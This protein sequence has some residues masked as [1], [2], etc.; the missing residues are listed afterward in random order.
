MGATA[1][2]TPIAKY[3]KKRKNCPAS[4]PAAKD[5]GPSQ[6]IITVSVVTIATHAS[7]MST[8]GTAS[9]TVARTS[10]DQSVTVCDAR[11][12][13]CVIA[14]MIYDSIA[15]GLGVPGLEA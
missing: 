14:F 2:S 3:S 7:S 12:G 13:R 15:K 1:A 6:P 4:A 8:S 11:P 5:S 9:V 10:C